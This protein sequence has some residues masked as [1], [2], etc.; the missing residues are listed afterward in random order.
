MKPD[1]ITSTNKPTVF[2]FKNLH[3]L[4]PIFSDLAILAVLNTFA[5]NKYIKVRIN[6]KKTFNKRPDIT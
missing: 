2:I 4:Y 6:E 1:N 5:V 3:T